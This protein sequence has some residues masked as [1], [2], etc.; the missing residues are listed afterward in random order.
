MTAD[1]R[2]GEAPMPRIALVSGGFGIDSVTEQ[3]AGHRGDPSQCRKVTLLP[4][5]PLTL[6]FKD[7]RQLHAAATAFRFLQVVDREGIPLPPDQQIPTR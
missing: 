6:F 7:P 2:P 1:R 4:S 5:Y 3:P